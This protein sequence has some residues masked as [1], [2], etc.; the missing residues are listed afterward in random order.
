MG[1]VFSG[2]FLDQTS[3]NPAANQKLGWAELTNER[4]G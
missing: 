2:L 4:P 1:P 3:A